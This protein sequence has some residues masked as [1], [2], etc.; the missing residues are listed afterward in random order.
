M[1]GHFATL[2]IAGC[3]LTGV[4]RAQ[5]A[6]AADASPSPPPEATAP[7]P[8]PHSE[9][10]APAGPEGSSSSGDP[11]GATGGS[12]GPGSAS[13]AGA[14][15]EERFRRACAA[16]E[17]GH[18]QEAARDFR[19]LL[20]DGYGEARI[21]YNLSCALYRSGDLGG[22]VLHA[23][24][25]ARLD[26]GDPDTRDNLAFLRGQI[27]DKDSG[28]AGFSDEAVVRLVD[29]FAA[30][31]R[32]NGLAGA[33]LAGEWIAIA[34]AT[35]ALRRRASGRAGR[36][37]RALWAGVA[38]ASALAIVAAAGL[39]LVA[40]RRESIQEAVVLSEK[41]DAL[42]GPGPT[43]P[44]LFSVHAGLKVRVSGE[45]DGWLQCR[46]PNGLSGWLEQEEVGVIQ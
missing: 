29:R 41:A 35:V 7:Q 16:Y 21:H 25:A 37:G 33:V 14:S 15:A 34:C 36:A 2:L 4:I 11:G 1:R 26:P 42:A 28:P 22:A 38:A 19:R 9:T 3:C 46:L 18:H 40:W 6:G 32:P 13:T 17:A 8:Q 45:R 20:A 43:H 10:T 30:L 5:G 24:T 23:E 31:A 39:G 27:V 44:V 12:G